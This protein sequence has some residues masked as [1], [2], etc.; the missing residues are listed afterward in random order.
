MCKKH[1]YNEKLKLNT[2]VKR[3][4][5]ITHFHKNI[6]KS[7]KSIKISKIKNLKNHHKPFIFRVN[8]LKIFRIIQNH[9]K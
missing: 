9:Q 5:Q 4:I 3:I 1:K 2:K 8:I 7:R 6:L